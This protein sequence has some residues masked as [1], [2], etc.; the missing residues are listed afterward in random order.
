M[1]KE[2]S[3]SFYNSQRWQ[4]TRAAFLSAHPY[5]NRH[6]MVGIIVPAEHV[7]H[8]VEL[9]EQNIDDPLV[10]LSWDNLEALCHDC[11]TREH[12]ANSQIDDGLFF[13]SDGN[14]RQIIPPV[15]IE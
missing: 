11:H 6:E 9:T 5:C 15:D 1:A 2:F 12:T 4:K 7:H 13:D 14:I 8:I 10:S 3:K